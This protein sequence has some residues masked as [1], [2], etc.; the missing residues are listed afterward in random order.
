MPLSVDIGFM[1]QVPP[2]PPSDQ[3][4]HVAVRRVDRLRAS[5]AQLLLVTR[6][7]ALTRRS[8]TVDLLERAAHVIFVT[9]KNWFLPSPDRDGQVPPVATGAPVSPPADYNKKKDLDAH[10]HD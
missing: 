3:S 7:R 6:L 8:L 10:R 9:C 4:R 2:T 5:I 1:S